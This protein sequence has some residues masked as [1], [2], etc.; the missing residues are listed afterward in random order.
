[1]IGFGKCPDALSFPLGKVQA[2]K[3]LAILLVLCVVFVVIGCGMVD[4]PAERERRYKNIGDYQ[5]RMGVDDWDHFWLVDRP[6]YLS[7][8]HLREAD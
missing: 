5:A 1:M 3:Q 4:T 6:S 2:M 7:Y 8:W